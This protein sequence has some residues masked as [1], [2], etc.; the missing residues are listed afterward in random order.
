MNIKTKIK[1]LSE[2]TFFNLQISKVAD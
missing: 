1:S 2:E